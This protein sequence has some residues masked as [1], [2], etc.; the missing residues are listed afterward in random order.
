MADLS[1]IKAVLRDIEKAIDR[2]TEAVKEMTKPDSGRVTV[3]PP[4][5]PLR[6]GAFN[7]DC[8]FCSLPRGHNGMH[9]EY[10]T[11]WS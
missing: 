8:Y 10:G 3:A 9:F 7:G 11:R 1:D 2:L 4:T 5:D 6:C